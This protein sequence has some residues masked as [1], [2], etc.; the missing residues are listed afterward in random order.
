M[1]LIGF[2]FDDPLLTKS[3]T[4]WGEFK[5]LS[6]KKVSWE[7]FVHKFELTFNE[8]VKLNIIYS[9][10]WNHVWGSENKETDDWASCKKHSYTRYVLVSHTSDLTKICGIQFSCT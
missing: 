1:E 9:A 3:Q 6:N 7:S 5:T 4:W 10:M 2:L 8:G